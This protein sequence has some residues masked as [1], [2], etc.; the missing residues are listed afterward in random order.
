MI[1]HLQLHAALAV[2]TII[3]FM[4][5]YANSSVCGYNY[6]LHVILHLQLQAALAV[7]TIILFRWL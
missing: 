4:W 6:S 3:L 7:L 5:S 1:L 2:V